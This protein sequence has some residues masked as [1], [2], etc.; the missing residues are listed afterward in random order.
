M[1]NIH[2]FDYGKI[3]SVNR[4]EWTKNAPKPFTTS[5]LQQ[6]M[7]SSHGFSPK[8]TMD[9]AQKLYEN[10]HITYMRTDSTILS[11]EAMNQIIAYIMQTYGEEYAKPAS[12][13]HAEGAHEAIRPTNIYTLP[14]STHS[15]NNM[16]EYEQKLYRCIWRRTVESMMTGAR[17]Y[18]ITVSHILDLPAEDTA[19][20]TPEDT[21]E[22]F[23]WISTQST[24]VFDGW[25]IMQKRPEDASRLTAVPPSVTR[26]PRCARTIRGIRRSE[27]Y[28]YDKHR[29][30]SIFLG[31]FFC[32]QVCVWRS[33]T[34]LRNL[35]CN[36]RRRHGCVGLKGGESGIPTM[37]TVSL[38]AAKRVPFCPESG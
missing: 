9:I 22:A 27:G 21:Q 28:Q 12:S 38:E 32:V 23:T 5:T 37:H 10:G 31:G 24:T 19:E 3:T 8:M 17:G 6:T 11:Q 20:D 33:N 4:K 25:K 35:S 7:S 14:D 18:E 1:E 15:T 34:R 13:A 30:G 16:N 26:I 29:R 36:S 2:T